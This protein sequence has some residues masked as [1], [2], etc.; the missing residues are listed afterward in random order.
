MPTDSFK[1]YSSV[2]DKVTYYPGTVTIRFA[3]GSEYIYDVPRKR[4]F[5]N[6]VKAPSVGRYFNTTF[7]KHYGPGFRTI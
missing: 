1:P 7:K 4:A 2:I 3:N 5:H 6:L